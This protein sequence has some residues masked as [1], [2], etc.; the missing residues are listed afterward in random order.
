[1]THV[2]YGGVHMNLDHLG[3]HQLRETLTALQ[4]YVDA[5]MRRMLPTVPDDGVDARERPGPVAA[6]RARRPR[7]RAPQRVGGK[8]A[9]GSVPAL[10]RPDDP[11][12]QVPFDPAGC[13]RR[14]A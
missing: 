8:R 11:A 9:G 12:T 7:P 10:G 2:G 13:S 14:A 3:E 6:A 1:M 4:A 5:A